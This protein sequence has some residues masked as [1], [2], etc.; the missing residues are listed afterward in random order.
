MRCLTDLGEVVAKDSQVCFWD[1]SLSL[2]MAVETAPT[3]T[4]SAYAD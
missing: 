2:P 3:Q 1:N 4:K